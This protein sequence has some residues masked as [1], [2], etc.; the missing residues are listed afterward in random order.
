MAIGVGVPSHKDT[1][2]RLVCLLEIASL[3]TKTLVPVSVH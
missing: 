1:L 3:F 2:L